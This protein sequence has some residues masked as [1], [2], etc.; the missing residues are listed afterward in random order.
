MDGSPP[1]M[2]L[3]KRAPASGRFNWLSDGRGVISD[4]NV[5]TSG[6]L[7]ITDLTT[8]A[9]RTVANGAFREA[10]PSLSPDG[11]TLAFAG[12][13]MA[14]DVV[15]VPLDGS[16]PRDVIATSRSEVAPA[17]VPDGVRFLY[18]TDRSGK[19]EIWLHN[20]VDG[21]ERL[22]VGAQQLPGLSALLDLEVSPDSTRVAYRANI[23]GE[24]MVWISPLS[25]DAP[26]RLWG[27]PARSWQRGPVWS[28]D[29]NWIA[30]YGNHNGRPAVMKARVGA[31]G[32]GEFLA[33]LDLQVPVRWSPRGDWIAFQYGDSLRVVSPDGKQN[34]EVSQHGWW[35]Y[36][37]SKDGSAVYGIRSGENRRQLL[38]MVDVATGRETQIGDLGPV[39][40]EFDALTILADNA[41]RGFSLH[42]G[43]KSFLTSIARV[44]TQIYLR[45]DFDRPTHLADQLLGR[46]RAR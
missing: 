8:G 20:R 17:W 36:G 6:N 5:V 16:K 38:V 31:N 3:Q 11:N 2:M 34:R 42:P 39:P 43:G 28:P 30:Y 41:Y 21:S 45:K 9:K 32:P 4:V 15:E 23:G 29:G 25:G 19:P 7:S 27:D 40:A 26:V 10:N 14:Y 35:T 46:W 13:E 12:G 22:I 44:K 37:W 24:V 33:N 18:V 1:Q